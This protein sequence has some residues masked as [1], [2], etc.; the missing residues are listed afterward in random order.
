MDITSL[1]FACIYIAV[2]VLY[3]A[4]SK[5][6]YER[7]VGTFP[8]FKGS[9]MAVA[10]LAWLAMALG[11][12]VLVA[13]PVKIGITRK[14]NPWSVGLYYGVV[15][16]FVV[17]GVFNFTNHVMYESWKVGIMMRDLVWGISWVSILTVAYA[18]YLKSMMIQS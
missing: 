12:L 15:Y 1:V 16:G 7:A 10:P 5:K 14:E 6:V 13:T 9:R 3:V 18:F 4:T 17:Y 8:D 11:W 2:D